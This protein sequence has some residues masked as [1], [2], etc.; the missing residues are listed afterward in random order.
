MF[1]TPEENE[2]QFGVGV[3]QEDKVLKTHIHKVFKREINNCSFTQEYK[4]PHDYSKFLK[5]KRTSTGCHQ[6]NILNLMVQISMKSE[7]G[8]EKA[9]YDEPCGIG[10]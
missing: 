9:N 1:P 8:T 10:V 4:T 7:E 2:L 6:A 3:A 5:N